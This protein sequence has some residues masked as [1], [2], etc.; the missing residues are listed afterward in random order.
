[1]IAYIL[2][3]VTALVIFVIFAVTIRDNTDNKVL[4]NILD[5][6][7]FLTACGYMVAAFTK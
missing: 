7:G 4:I 6:T 1:M 3:T 5:L 2:Y